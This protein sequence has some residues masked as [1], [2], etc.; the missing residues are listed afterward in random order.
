MDYCLKVG[1]QSREQPEYYAAYNAGVSWQQAVYEYAHCL[2]KLSRCQTIIDLG[3]GDGAKLQRFVPEFEVVGLDYGDNFAYCQSHYSQ[4]K[5]LE[6]DLEDVT[7]Y[8]RWDKALLSGALIICA[9]VIEHLRQPEV[10]LRMMRRWLPSVQGIVISTP[11]RDLTHGKAH[12]GPPPNPCHVREWN[13]AEF[14]RLMAQFRLRVTD[15]R[16]VPAYHGCSHDET[17]M[18]TLKA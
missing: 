3:C 13:T 15:C 14:L 2:A 8:P 9:D 5:W 11:E 6:C 17:L 16:C 1:Y 18:V 7:T 4:S 12:Q 10:L